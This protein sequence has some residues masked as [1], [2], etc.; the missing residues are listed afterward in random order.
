MGSISS[1]MQHLLAQYQLSDSALKAVGV[2][3]IGTR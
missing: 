1:T 2:G 3:S